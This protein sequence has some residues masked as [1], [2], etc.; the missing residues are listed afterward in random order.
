MLIPTNTF[1]RVRLQNEQST[2]R[3]LAASNGMDAHCRA[4]ACTDR[5]IP[6]RTQTE[7]TVYLRILLG[8]ERT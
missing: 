3:G 2:E 1:L 6:A 7:G 4:D 5:D 8:L